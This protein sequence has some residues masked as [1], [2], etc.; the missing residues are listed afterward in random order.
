MKQLCDREFCGAGTGTGVTRVTLG[1]HGGDPGVDLRVP[2]TE[3][4]RGRAEE[5]AL[6]LERGSAASRAQQGHSV[7]VTTQLLQAHRWAPGTV[8]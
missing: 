2:R 8:P 5:V 7:T 3:Q 1:W 4:L 6:A